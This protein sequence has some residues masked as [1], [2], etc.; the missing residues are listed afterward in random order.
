[1]TLYHNLLRNFVFYCRDRK[2][3][4]ARI[5]QTERE[6]R[7]NGTIP[8]TGIDDNE[9]RNPCE[10]VIN[11]TTERKYE[12][13]GHLAP[14]TQYPSSK[15]KP[16]NA[17]SSYS[18]SSCIDNQ[19]HH[20]VENLTFE[21]SFVDIPV[22]DESQED[23][24]KLYHSE[25]KVNPAFQ[26]TCESNPVIFYAEKQVKPY[27]V[28]KTV[29]NGKRAQERR[30]RVNENSQDKMLKSASSDDKDAK[31][32]IE[33][34]HLSPECLAVKKLLRRY[35]YEVAISDYT[36]LPNG[37]P[38]PSY[39]SAVNDVDKQDSKQKSQQAPKR[40][41]LECEN[42]AYDKDEQK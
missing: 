3:V 21:R 32:Q 34:K 15:I 18:S 8:E 20:G 22:A 31:R 2:T 36:W 39:A 42:I 26:S 16:E 30:F 9:I 10:G 19:R 5:A 17:C 27:T 12:S 4:K 7:T 38:P 11:H 13:N 35:S 37:Q 23:N 28:S 41:S 25:S 29:P 6:R 1:M 14:E 40:F 33:M 24:R